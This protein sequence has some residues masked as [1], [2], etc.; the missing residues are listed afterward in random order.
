[1]SHKRYYIR[2][3]AQTTADGIVKASGTFTTLDG[4]PLAREGDPVDC[5]AC[6]EQGVIQCVAPRLPDQAEG[7]QYALSDD[8]CV[9]GCSP[10]PKLLADRFDDFQIVDDSPSI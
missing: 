7:K 9:C 1:M 4:I 10:P 5:P 6:G 8:L 3:G 2:D